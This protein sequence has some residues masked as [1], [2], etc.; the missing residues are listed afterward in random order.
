MYRRH[1]S[2][3][4]ALKLIRQYLAALTALAAFA[5]LPAGAHATGASD[6]GAQE[7]PAQGEDSS[8]HTG[9]PSGPRPQN[10]G[11]Q[12]DAPS[13]PAA[14]PQAAVSPE[15][16][17]GV[18]RATPGDTFDVVASA[19]PARASRVSRRAFTIRIA[20]GIHVRSAQV[21]VDGVAAPVSYGRRTTARVDLRGKPRG[22]VSVRIRV[23]TREGAAIEATRE[24]RT[25]AGK[26]GG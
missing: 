12:G 24:Y 8:G 26:G 23:R 10:A 16:A 20:R 17:V 11:D 2:R 15:Q 19:D 13:D 1:H 21:W 6:Q 4:M 14:A 7:Q 25:C 5:A 18:T 22:H 9:D 3:H